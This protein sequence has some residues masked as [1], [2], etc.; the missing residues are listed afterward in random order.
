MRRFF[1][2]GE[3]SDGF[4]VLMDAEAKHMSKVLRIEIGQT[5]ILCDGNGNDYQT[6]VEQIAQDAVKLKLGSKILENSEPKLDV[7][8]YLAYTKGDH[9]D[10]AVQKSVELGA[11]E[12]KLF[13]CERCIAKT[14]ANKT[15]RL[16]RIAYEASKQSGRSK[17]VNVS[18]AGRLS[19]VL[20]AAKGLKLFCYELESKPLRLEIIN[21]P[22]KVSV[23]C[24]PE[25][26]FTNNEAI[27]AV[28]TGWKSVSLGKRI[29][30]AE[31]APLAVLA[32]LMYQAFDM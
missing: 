32:I 6:T 27:F 17:L 28:K 16:N 30:R 18:D 7:T 14:S 22:Q 13:S 8:L 23:I 4:V 1:W 3:S 29:L 5:V 10:F 15:E 2:N 12:I 19:D 26:G 25:G 24:G 9:L 20:L 21:I 11:S 31:T